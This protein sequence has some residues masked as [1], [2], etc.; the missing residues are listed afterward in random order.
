MSPQSGTGLY[1]IHL[2]VALDNLHFCS[3]LTIFNVGPRSLDP[4][5]KLPYKMGQD[6]WDIRYLMFTF[7]ATRTTAYFSPIFVTL[8]LGWS[9]CF[10][11]FF[12]LNFGD[13]RK[14]DFVY[15]DLILRRLFLRLSRYDSC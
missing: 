2:L 15:F 4:F 14:S 1:Q 12:S 6:F 3:S 13:E 7:F 9:Y 5:Y 8:S 10:Y 11:I